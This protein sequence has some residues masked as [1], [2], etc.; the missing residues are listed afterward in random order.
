MYFWVYYARIRT[1][2]GSFIC[3]IPTLLVI[4]VILY[5]WFMY[6]ILLVVDSCLFADRSSYR[7]HLKHSVD[8][9]LE[10]E[11]SIEACVIDIFEA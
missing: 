3:D 1:A 6:K 2:V 11:V 5:N 4:S 9:Y 10:N 8:G 7:V